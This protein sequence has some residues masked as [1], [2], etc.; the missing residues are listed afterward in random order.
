FL[1]DERDEQEDVEDARRMHRRPRL[2]TREDEQ[3][4]IGHEREVAVC[5]MQKC[6]TKPAEIQIRSAIA[7]D[8]AYKEAQ[9]SEACKGMRDVFT[10]SKIFLVPIKEMTDVLSVESKSI[11]ISRD[12]EYNV[13]DFTES[14][15]LV[16]CGCR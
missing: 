5:L 9:V 14:S 3:E 2:I 11:N 6:I 1:A 4:D 12:S 16:G 8:Q 15:S 10:C 7:L 13:T